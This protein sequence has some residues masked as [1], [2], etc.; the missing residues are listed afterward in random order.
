MTLVEILIAVFILAVAVI[1]LAGTAASSLKSVRI[2]RDRQDATQLASTILEEARGLP[3]EDV[4]LD[5]ADAPPN[6]FDPVTGTGGCDPASAGCEA[7]VKLSGGSIDHVRTTGRHTATTYV[8]EVEGTSG[9]QVRVTAFVSW[10]DGGN[11]RTVREETLIAQATRGLPVPTFTVTPVSP[12]ATGNPGETLCLDHTIL[13]TGEEDGY[14]WALFAEN[15]T[16]G[17]VD[18]GTLG[19][20][21]VREPDGAGGYTEETRQGFRIH[22]DS[23][24]KHWFGWAKIAYP[25]GGAL[26]P[27]TDTT[28]DGR[29][30]SPIRVPALSEARITFCYTALNASGVREALGDDPIFTPRIY[31]AFDETVTTTSQNN[32][33]TNTIQVVQP[34]TALYLHES[35]RTLNTSSAPDDSQLDYDSDGIAGLALADSPTSWSH[36]DFGNL[37][38]AQKVLSNPSVTLFVR[39]TDTDDASDTTANDETLTYEVQVQRQRSGTTTTVADASVTFTNVGTSWQQVTIVPSFLTSD[40]ADR[41]FQDNDLIFVSLACDAATSTDSC[42]VNYDSTGFMSAFSGDFQ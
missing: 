17:S 42:H 10:S 1:A 36:S 16:T 39:A 25:P 14:S 21:T 6:G 30:D 38:S 40:V 24:A 37:F 41:T 12:S 13:N 18:Q 19:T 4:I 5:T 7:V 15:T 22:F 33:L 8:S 27:M 31:S 35:G 28:G 26:Q 9:K 11:E 23:S 3:F 20:R 32:E 29:P 2:S 34:N